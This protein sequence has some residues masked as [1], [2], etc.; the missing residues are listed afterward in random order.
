VGSIAWKLKHGQQVNLLALGYGGPE[1]DAPYLTDSIMVVS[2]DAGSQRIV[3]ASLPRDLYVGIDAWQDGTRI[4]DKINAAFEVPNQPRDFAPGP[5]KPQFQGKDGAGHLAEATISRLTGLTFDRY[6]ALDFKAF[7]D[8]VDALGGVQV[9]MDGPLD[10]CHYPDYHDGYVNNG[11]P[12]GYD[13]PPGAGIH[14]QAGDY[15][16]NGEQA[17]QLARS[18]DA[19]QP[20][21]A[22][23]FGRSKR[24]QMIVAAIKKKAASVSAITKAPQL[25]DALQNN[26]QTDMDLTD[27]KAVYDFASKLPDQAIGHLAI[28]DQNLLDGFNPYSRGSCGPPDAFVLCPADD[29]YRTLQAVFAR[30]F[31]P[32]PVLA[33]QAPVQLV[34][35]S[36]SSPD[37][38]DRATDVLHQLGLQTSQGIR[39]RALASSTVYDYSGGRY[40]ATAAWLRDF[41]GAEV[42]PAPSPP[43]AQQP[44]GLVVMMGSDFARHWNGLA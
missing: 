16:V 15:L 14:F 2:L 35:A 9:H 17:L 6:A 28:T 29:T 44:A 21:Q 39:S 1:N 32:K 38:Q 24:Q 40:P 18:R 41:F 26:F 27:M 13:C 20:E 31:V 43:A 42:V 30:A 4:T 5:L 3:E 25:M 34:N 19:T 7:R 33:E 12:P 22:N 11:V 23:D 8:V 10:D 36:V 37:L